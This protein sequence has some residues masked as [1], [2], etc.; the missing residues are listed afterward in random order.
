MENLKFKFKWLDDKGREQGYLSKKGSFDGESLR[1]GDAT[2]PAIAITDVDVRGRYMFLTVATRDEPT[3]IAFVVKSG[4]PQNLKAML[5]RARSAAWAEMHRKQLTE[6]GRGQKFR[7]AKCPFCEATI[8]LT[9]FDPTPQVSCEFCHAIAMI[10]GDGFSFG[11]EAAGRGLRHYRI[12]D[13]CGM[14]S[15][16]RLFTIFYFYF[17][18]V[19]YG[20]RHGST[21]RCPACMRPEAWKML[22]GNLLFVLGVPVAIVQLFRSY[23]GTDVGGPYPGLDKANLKARQGKQEAAIAE[24]Q[25]ILDKQ[26]TAAGVKYNIGLAFL[27]QED[28]ER[29]A[30][31][32]EYA[33]QDC[34]NYHPAAVALAGCYEELG[35][36]EKLARLQGQWGGDAGGEAEQQAA[37]GTNS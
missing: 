17:L 26:P 37:E 4:K 32:F 33:L 35:Q 21:W 14:Y 5:G 24:Y 23:G 2:V 36:H 13:E 28:F 15:K 7:A 31:M 12:C 9:N 16:P 19:F 11:G 34:A 18:F 6:E 29:A 22:F 30:R 27:D 20:F 3:P 25:A 1:L 10:E 8:D